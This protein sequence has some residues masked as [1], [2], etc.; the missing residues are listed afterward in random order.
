MQENIMISCDGGTSKGREVFW[1]I[2]VSTSPKRKVCL[3][4]CCEA[5]SECHTG[6]WIKNFVLEA[7]VI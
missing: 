3:M 5:T 7:R 4:E 2:H 6:V 1:T